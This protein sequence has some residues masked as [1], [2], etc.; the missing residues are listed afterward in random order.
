MSSQ[1]QKTF[2][3]APRRGQLLI[4]QK[5]FEAALNKQ[6]LVMESPTGSG[7]TVSVLSALIDALGDRKIL[8]LTRTNSQ[9]KQVMKELRAIASRRHVF[10]LAVQGRNSSCLLARE[11]D[12]LRSGSPEELSVFCSRMK[13]L[14]TSPG[15]GCKF[16][17]GLTHL[18]EGR[19][20]EWVRREMPDSEALVSEC[21][22]REICPYE[23]SKSLMHDADVVTAPYVYFFNPFIRRRLLEWMGIPIQRLMVVVDEA[24]NLPDYLRESESMLLSCRAAKAAATEAEEFTDP[25]VLHGVSMHDFAELMERL[26]MKMADDYVLEEDGIIPES[27]LETELMEALHTGSRALQAVVSALVGHGEFVR[28][29]KLKQ[30]RLPRSYL[31]H[32]GEF[33][34]FWMDAGA[35]YYV[36]TV[37]SGDNPS[38]ELYCLDPSN[39]AMPLLDTH[40]S[41][42]MSGTMGNLRD[43]ATI[44]RLPE[45]TL[46]LH[47]PSDFPKENKRLVYVPDITTRYETITKDASMI[48][49]ISARIC[50]IFNAVRRN[51]MVFFPSHGLLE[52]VLSTGI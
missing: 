21:Q 26:I 51:T 20:E 7:K 39:A 11:D 40:C 19:S 45:D 18:D 13:E 34:R 38:L 1:S 14:S 52:S 31:R 32:L 41:I 48:A 29:M 25:E 16:Y 35:E 37:N 9:Q 10:G 4:M 44:L 50:E 46:L 24:H 15:R 47:V 28:D 5:V 22:G 36:K 2:P 6:H 8:Y 17:Y 42:H 3:Y 49:Q 33:L 12:E 30:N 27:A 23:L 43:Y